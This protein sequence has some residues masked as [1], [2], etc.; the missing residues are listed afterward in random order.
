MPAFNISIAEVNM[1]NEEQVQKRV[2]GVPLQGEALKKF[3]E[4]KAKQFIDQDAVAAR[5]LIL[6]RLA[7]IEEAE[8]E[9][10]A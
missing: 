5:K 6:E 7:Q 10:A 9:L 2:V 4:Y 3:D 1:Q 8:K